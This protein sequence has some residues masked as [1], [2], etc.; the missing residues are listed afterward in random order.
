[1]GFDLGTNSRPPTPNIHRLIENGTEAEMGLIPVFL[2]LLSLIIIPLLPVFILLIMVFINNHFIDPETGEF[3]HCAS[4]EPKWWLGESLWETVVNHGLKAATYIWPGSEDVTIIMVGDHGMV[5]A[6]DKKL[7]FLEDLAQWIEIPAEWVLSYSPLLAIRPP[8]GNEPS[9]VVAKMTKDWN[10]RALRWS[11]KG[12]NE[13]SAEDHMDMTMQFSPRG[14][15]YWSWS[16][17]CEGE[18]G[19]I[20]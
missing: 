2:L 15:F 5:G 19:A 20:F 1:M 11:R 13:K 4:H 14:A 6:C 9:D 10:P 8:P 12:L 17:I 18:E 7:I 16:S 3:F